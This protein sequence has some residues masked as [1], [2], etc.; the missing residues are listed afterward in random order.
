MAKE[1]DK[2]TSFYM[3]LTS[4]PTDVYELHATTDVTVNYNSKVTNFPVADRK[5]SAD[6]VVIDP[7]TITL[8][9]VVTDVK[10]TSSFLSY[11]KVVEVFKSF[12]G[13]SKE[14]TEDRD[15]TAE[16]Y[17]NKLV[18]NIEAAEA[19]DIYLPTVEPILNCII[20]SFSINKTAN[21]GGD[22][23]V[24]TLTLQ[25]VRQ[26]TQT[27]SAASPAEPYKH[28]LAGQGGADGNGT[29]VDDKQAENAC[30]QGGIQICSTGR[31]DQ[32]PFW[33][34]IDG[35]KYR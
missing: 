6:N 8:N 28:L 7:T 4:K 20:T 21:Y 1:K 33:I 22:S 32:G 12:F 19:F 18:E 15:K 23:W 13:D 5:N 24:I 9:G 26:A 29:G 25:K 31:D 34:G 17:I 27:T 16:D 2:D 35:I 30:K 14:E 10:Q 11:G 3:Q